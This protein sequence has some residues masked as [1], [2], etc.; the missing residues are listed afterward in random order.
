MNAKLES[1]RHE[2][3]RCG[4]E[5]QEEAFAE[6]QWHHRH[7]RGATCMDCDEKANVCHKLP[8]KYADCERDCQEGDWHWLNQNRTEGRCTG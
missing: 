7:V 5:L 8:Q 1:N 4:R 6:S 3:A 2:C